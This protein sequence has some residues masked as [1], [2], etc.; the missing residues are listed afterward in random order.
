MEVGL[1]SVE[2]NKLY[3]PRPI[4]GKYVGQ[5][6]VFWKVDLFCFQKNRYRCI[7]S[8]MFTRMRYGGV[9]V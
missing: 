8:V 6:N 5:N 7:H 4:A 3:G 9:V 2:S 1:Q